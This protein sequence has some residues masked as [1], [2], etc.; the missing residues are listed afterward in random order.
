LPKDFKYNLDDFP[1]Q[2]S[3]GDSG[4]LCNWAKYCVYWTKEA[5]N[6]YSYIDTNGNSYYE[7]FDAYNRHLSGV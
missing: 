6:C 2:M 7:C 4:T 5:S 1:F 3:Y